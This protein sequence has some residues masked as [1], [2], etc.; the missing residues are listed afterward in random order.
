MVVRCRHSPQPDP[1]C[2]AWSPPRSAAERIPGLVPLL[3]NSP[4][5]AEVS[6]VQRLQDGFAAAMQASLFSQAA[7]VALDAPSAADGDAG[8]DAG[9]G[10]DS[11][12]ALVLRLLLDALERP[13]PNLTH[14]LCGFDAD[15]ATGLM[16]LPDPRGQYNV[17]RVLLTA[18]EVTSTPQFLPGPLPATAPGCLIAASLQLPEVD[19]WAGP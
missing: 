18:I 1:P 12:A 3:L 13:P 11:R 19:P 8:G 10:G 16:Y 9:G 17:L 15:P 6:A 4:P 2:L 5:T 7:S 14:L